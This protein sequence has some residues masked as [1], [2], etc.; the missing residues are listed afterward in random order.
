[1]PRAKLSSFTSVCCCLICCLSCACEQCVIHRHIC[2]EVVFDTK[3]AVISCVK[4]QERLDREERKKFML[5]KL[6][7]LQVRVTMTGKYYFTWQIGTGAERIVVCRYGFEMAY[8]ITRWYSDD[9][10]SRFKDGDANVSA[11]FTD[12]TALDKSGINDKRVIAF[13]KHFGI[14]LNRRQIRALKIPNSMQSLSTVAWM[15][16]YFKLMADNVPNIAEELHLEPVKK[17]A[18]YEEYCFDCSSYSDVMVPIALALFLAIWRSVFAYVKVRKFKQCCG[19][20]NLCA[21]LSELRRKFT[22]ARGREEVSR[23]F[24]VHQ[25]TYMGEREGYYAR[26]HLAMHE[27]WHY[28]STITDGMQQN[29]CLLPWYGHKKQPPLHL[30][31]HLQGILMHGRQMR[32]YR[33]VSLSTIVCILGFSISKSSIKTVSSLLLC[34][35]I[36]L[37]VAPRMPTFFTLQCALCK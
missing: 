36:R 29:R 23:L 1:M 31:Q 22:D 8:Q 28:L 26:R 2:P 37:M 21:L 14:A 27:P 30:K 11:C 3:R 35:F 17:A 16:Y 25:M 6:K 15:N 33:S 24:E 9:L 13:C 34:Y 32:I 19:K 10:I 12:R 20:C 7:S 5:D 4:E 18:I